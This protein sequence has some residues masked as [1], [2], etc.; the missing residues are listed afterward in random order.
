MHILEECGV[1]G[2]D[3]YGESIFGAIQ[4]LLER[5]GARLADVACYAAASGPGSF[6]GVRTGLTAAKGLGEASGKPVV[7]VSNLEALAWCGSAALRAPVMDARR[8][9]VFGAVYDAD[10]KIVQDEVVTTLAVWLGQVPS[11]AQI[12]LWGAMDGAPA[13]AA[14]YAT[15]RA[16]ERLAGAIAAIAASRYIEG[17]SQ[18]AAAIDANYVRRADAELMWRDV[19]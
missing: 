14:G 10:M 9:E 11:G 5:Q 8:G 13:E 12:V 6:T 19:K 1:S 17:L 16:P 7:A 2:P 4:A 18:D 15:L 3:G